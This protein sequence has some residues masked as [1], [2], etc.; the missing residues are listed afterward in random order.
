MEIAPSRH[1]CVSTHTEWELHHLTDLHLDERG[2]AE[3]ELDARIERIKDN[4]RALWAG[5]GDYGG[6][7]LPGDPR[8]GDGWGDDVPPARIPD[9]VVE[10]VTE[11]LLPIRDK[12]I[13]FGIGNHERTVQLKFHRGVGAEIAANLGVSHL[14]LGMRGWMPVTFGLR[15]GTGEK[16][17]TK[18]MTL[19]VYWHHGWSAGRSKSRKVLHEERDLGARGAHVHLV[20]HDHQPWINTW[21]EEDIYFDSRNRKWKIRHMPVC[22]MNGGSWQLGQEPPAKGKVA[23]KASEVPNDSWVESKNYRPE[24]PRSPVLHVLVDFGAGK[25]RAN[26]NAGRPQ[27]FDFREEM[28][29]PRFYVE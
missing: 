11:K 24:P 16:K 6:L 20:G 18:T 4:P 1:D 12:C 2:F 7:I 5:G 25:D 19:K 9:Y 29:S 26:R 10:V 14:Y 27:G 15:V 22:F 17:P 28:S 3:K 8:S 21:Y 23:R 13:G